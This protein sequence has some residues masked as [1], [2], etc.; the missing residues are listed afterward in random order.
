MDICTHVL[1]VLASLFCPYGKTIA[2]KRMKLSLLALSLCSLM[3]CSESQTDT[4]Q[5]DTMMT[6]MNGGST[7]STGESGQM[8]ATT[9]DTDMGNDGAMS[10]STVNGS[11]ANTSSG[12]NNSGSRTTNGSNN[13]QNRNGGSQASESANSVSGF[14]ASGQYN[15]NVRTPEPV[16]LDNKRF[17]E[18]P[19]AHTY[20]D[21]APKAR[22]SYR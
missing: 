4:T 20:G 15:S 5:Q 12:T 16:N 22:P 9:E 2:M 18:N 17:K 3:A 11:A 14:A 1:Q 8:Q 19:P 21:T 6:D 13:G 7:M 10:N